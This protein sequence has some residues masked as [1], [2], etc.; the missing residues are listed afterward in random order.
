MVIG[1]TSC[2]GCDEHRS[3]HGRESLA[4]VCIPSLAKAPFQDRVAVCREVLSPCTAL[5]M[6][7][8]A[9]DP[10]STKADSAHHQPNLSLTV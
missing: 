8:R 7:D 1:V 5:D 3:R 9:G 2:W 4:G 6:G 10:R